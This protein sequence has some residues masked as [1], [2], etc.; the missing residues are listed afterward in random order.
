V[1]KQ[2]LETVAPTKLAYYVAGSAQWTLTGGKNVDDSGKL[3]KWL[4]GK[5]PEAYDHY[6]VISLPPSFVAILNYQSLSWIHVLPADSGHS[7]IR[8]GAIFAKS[9]FKEDKQSKAFT[10]AFFAE[11]KWICE[12][13]QRGMHS[14]LGKGG[15]LVELEQSVV[16]FH[17]Y[18]AAKLFDTKVDDFVE[19][20]N[21]KIFKRQGES[22]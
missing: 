11:D 3:A 12:R 9:M 19:G 21:A 17:Q 4:R 15:K 14:T 16:D 13:V 18:L 22:T 8:S 2:T 6:L 1:H 7:V 5:Y 10:A 20:D